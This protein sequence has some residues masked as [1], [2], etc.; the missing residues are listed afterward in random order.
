M[1]S[2]NHTGNFH[3]KTGTYA[4]TIECTGSAPKSK[5]VNKSNTIREDPVSKAELRLILLKDLN[6][7]SHLYRT[8]VIKQ[9]ILQ[10]P[11]SVLVRQATGDLRGT[12]FSIRRKVRP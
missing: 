9:K 10:G 2:S 11:A 12:Y 3:T 8:K 7:W 5:F 4:E 6:R 1:Q